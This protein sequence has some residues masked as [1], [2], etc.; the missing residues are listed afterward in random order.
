MNKVFLKGNLTSDP[1]IREV[2]IGEKVSTVANFTIAVSRHY[3]Q[4]DGET[5]QQTEFIDCEAWDSAA[6][7][8]GKILHKGDPILLEG[9]LKK[10]QWEKDGQK[11]SRVKV[12]TTTFDKLARFTKTD[13]SS[14]T[15]S[16]KPE[17]VKVEVDAE[18]EEIPF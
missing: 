8:M 15:D 5:K 10:E 11:H 7:T 14:E 17:L 6:I 2:N 13:S 4:K 12:R 16:P 18:A 9:S 3:K 1:N